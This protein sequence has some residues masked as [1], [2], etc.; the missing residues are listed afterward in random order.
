[1]TTDPAVALDLFPFIRD[2]PDDTIARMLAGASVATFEPGTK[3]MFPGD[4][5]QT[6]AL[7]IDGEMRIHSISPSGRD[8][9][10]YSVL[11]GQMCALTS[12]CL[13][14]KQPFPAF[15]DVI[16]R[17]TV[18]VI[19]QA[20][21]DWLVATEGPWRQFAFRTAW[22]R[23]GDLLTRIDTVVF[24]DLPTRLA[25]ALLTAQSGGVARMTHADLAGEIGSSREAVSRLLKRWE[26]NGLISLMRGRILIDSL[27]DLARIVRGDLITLD[28]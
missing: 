23:V 11:P 28:P 24:T 3:L 2:L 4:V 21:F 5:C 20:E 19:S 9:T 12:L 18:V 13:L 22:D 15:V 7:V 8:L 27:E 26:R 6:C 16:E 10:L 14:T 25:D 17:T 1:M